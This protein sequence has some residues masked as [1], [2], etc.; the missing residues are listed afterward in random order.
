MN[1]D[2]PLAGIKVFDLSRILAGP[3]CTQL[4]AD[5]GAE[6]IKIEPPSGDD[7]RRFGPPFIGEESTYFL[8]VNRGK[9][10]LVLDL[11]HPDV[12]PI[13]EKLTHWADIVVENF[14]P[15]VAD[16]LGVGY[17][18]LNQINSRLI[19]VSIS[20]YGQQGVEPYTKLP[21][22][23]LVIQGIGGIPAI[24]GPENGSPYKVGTSIADLTAGMNAFGGSM[25]ALYEREQSGKGQHIDISMLDG[26]LALLSYH[27][28]ASLNAAQASERMG[29]AHPSICPYETFE[30]SDGYINIACGNDAQFEKLCN[31]LGQS[32]LHCERRFA[33][34]SDRV[35]NR[36]EL[37]VILSPLMKNQTLNS[38]I[39][40]IK[41]AGV[42]CGPILPVP[43]SLTHPQVEARNLIIEQEHV[44]AGSVRN[45]GSPLGFESKSY[46]TCAPPL[47]GEHSEAIL[48]E[49]LNFSRDEIEVFKSTG[50]L[51][52]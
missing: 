17:E 18:A 52:A 20:G 32:D 25:A 5:L 51:G 41:L 11:K 37:L 28:S 9:R 43:E 36:K 19:Y 13:V 23:D 50:V 16:K 49:S 30:T 48:S 38:L 14:R 27:G 39:K 10:S 29:N 2:G 1:Q 33:T 15:G 21:G 46:A 26:Q 35:K 45:I 6:I 24:T 8:S 44:V 47:C 40:K 22:Y 3:Y 4:M 7:T 12:R 34:N 42:P 31:A